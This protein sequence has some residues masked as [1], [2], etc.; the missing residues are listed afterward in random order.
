[1]SANALI[2]PFLREIRRNLNLSSEKPRA[3]EL[4]EAV[5][6]RRATVAGLF[7]VGASLICSEVPGASQIADEIVHATAFGVVADGK[8]DDAPALIKA[9]AALTDGS[10]LVLP[11]GT[12]ALGST[13][14][15]GIHFQG[16][17]NV[18]IQGSNTELLWLAVPLQAT[19]PFGATGLL[20][21]Q[22]RHVTV[23]DIAING[24]GLDC[25]GLGLDT[26]SSCTIAGVEAFGHG[27]QNGTG[28]GQ[29]VSCRG[30]DN[31]WIGCTARDSTP[32]SQYRGF[33]LGNANSGWGEFNLKIQGCTARNND[34][35]GFALGAERMICVGSTAEKN[36]GAGFI[37]GTAKG[38]NSVDH[39]FVANI[40]R[41]NSFHGWQTDSW[42]DNARRIVLS[43]NNFSDNVH[44][45]VYCHKGTDITIVGN[46]L[47]GNGNS[48]GAGAVALTTSQNV[49]VAN[50]MIKGDSTH[51]ICISAKFSQNE[52]S[53][54]IIA[55][56]R[57]VGSHSKTIWLEAADSSSFIQG[58]LLTGNIVDGGTHGV[59]LATSSA[60][61][62][63]QNVDVSNNLISGASEASLFLSDYAAGQSSNVRLVANSSDRL[64]LSKTM[65]TVNA[66]NSWNSVIGQGFGPPSTG[67]WNRGAIIYNSEPTLG[68]PLGWVCTTA[69]NPGVWNKFATIG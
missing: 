2:D 26:C 40:A 61:A 23:A 55:N 34:A 10:M 46:V 53:D 36:K 62:H 38:S 3:A 47:T 43:G 60:G 12:I 4:T 5:V 27:S 21:H 54:V 15:R 51:G 69:G 63:I 19:T 14:W 49:I 39:L 42:G 11:A 8:T 52:L 22:C 41:E 13:G 64:T 44:S 6:S 24:N 25:I 16:L 1:M 33:Y 37:S 30:T 29:L 28:L 58:L 18:R 67:I 50:N 7:G 57:C 65:P 66:N 45:G 32:G 48:T 9:T 68:A 20:L 59:F 35:T 17:T 31:S 56:N